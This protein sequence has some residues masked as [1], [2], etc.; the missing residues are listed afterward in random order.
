M[1][2]YFP[3]F[4]NYT[5]ALWLAPSLVIVDVIC[6]IV[7]PSLMSHIVD[8]GIAQK[9]LHYILVTGAIMVALSILAIAANIG[10][11]YYS[12]HASVGFA[13]E[14]RKGI[15][16]K[17]QKFS[18]SN[19]DKFSSASLVTRITNDVN[20]LQEVIMMSLR[21]LIRGPLMLL[22]AV[23]FAISINAPLAI[24]IAVAIPVLALAIFFILRKALPYF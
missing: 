11:I 1:R 19:L 23:G 15:F 8:Q 21:V 7:Q 4:K 13:A 3:Y 2:E 18:F 22:F 6:E 9:N 16:N 24:I 20:I 12:S 14:L 5:R 17:V 10:N